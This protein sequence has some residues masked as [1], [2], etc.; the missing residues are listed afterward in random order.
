MS[1]LTRQP[2]VEGRHYCV[3]PATGC[4]EWLGRQLRGYAHSSGVR[5]HRRMYI[6]AIGPIPAGCDL[7][8]ACR[9]KLCINPAHMQI[10]EHRGHVA[11][12]R[13]EDSTLTL[14]QV[15]R[16]REEAFAG[17]PLV[18]LAERYGLATTTVDDIVMGRHW[19]DVGGPIGRPPNTCAFCGAA[20]VGYRHRRYCDPT[21][22]RRAQTARDKTRRANG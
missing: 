16:L 19:P 21:C 3:D 1:E 13:R 22:R 2:Y 6:A 15:V 17:V 7:H 18:R 12:H 10:L 20:M 8:H 9:N 4:W 5:P 11:A 14:E